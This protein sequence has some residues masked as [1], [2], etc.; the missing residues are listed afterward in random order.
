MDIINCPISFWQRKTRGTSKSHNQELLTFKDSFEE[1]Q[2]KRPVQSHLSKC[3]HTA[4][5]FHSTF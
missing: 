1:K 5:L 2:G 3:I 4:L